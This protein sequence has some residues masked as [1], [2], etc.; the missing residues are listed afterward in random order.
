MTATSTSSLVQAIYPGSPGSSCSQQ[1]LRQST[2]YE[3]VFHLEAILP[4]K[5]KAPR[6]SPSTALQQV[7]LPHGRLAKHITAK[8]RSCLWINNNTHAECCSK[9]PLIASNQNIIATHYGKQW[10]LMQKRT[11]CTAS[12]LAAKM[13]H[14]V[15]SHLKKGLTCYWWKTSQIAAVQSYCIGAASHPYFCQQGLCS[16]GPLPCCKT[17]PAP[18]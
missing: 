18:W 11:P 7:W 6:R 4:S 9:V 3:H 16:A 17:H 12:L 1:N 15:H 10:G 2:S 5:F 8:Q 14:L 13:Q